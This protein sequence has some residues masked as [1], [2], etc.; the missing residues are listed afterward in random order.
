MTFGTPIKCKECG[1]EDKV[2]LFKGVRI[3]DLI[4]G[5]CKR[6]GTMRRNTYY[7]RGEERGPL[8]PNDESGDKRDGS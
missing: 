6:T 5:G 7:D 8:F 3:R 4:C 1:Y 2:R